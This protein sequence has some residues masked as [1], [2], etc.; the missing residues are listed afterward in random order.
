MKGFLVGFS[1]V[2]LGVALA[3][4]LLSMAGVATARYFMTRLSILPPKPLYGEEQAA[5][6]PPTAT[7]GPTEA[8]AP[9]PPESAPAPP[10]AEPELAPGTYKAVVVQP[11]GLIL[12]EGPGT[13]HPQVGGVDYNEALIVLEEPADQGWIKVRVVTSGQEGWVKT[14]NTQRTDN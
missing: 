10:A 3:L 7:P 2:V 4:M 14:G 11:I 8:P 13:E 5:T 6:V 12:R 9:A 1:K